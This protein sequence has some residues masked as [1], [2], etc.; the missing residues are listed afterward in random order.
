MQ[1]TFSQFLMLSFLALM[2]VAYDAK[3]SI[4]VV[5]NLTLYN[6]QKVSTDLSINSTVNIGQSFLATTPYITSISALFS[7]AGNCKYSIYVKKEGTDILNSSS[8][9]DIDKVTTGTFVSQA[10]SLTTITPASPIYVKVGTTYV[11]VFESNTIPVSSIGLYYKVNDPYPRGDLFQNYSYE[12]NADL[13]MTVVGGYPFQRKV[14]LYTLSNYFPETSSPGVY[15]LGN[16]NAKKSI[17]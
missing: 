14:D 11:I 16:R 3:A 10:G 13:C 5:D 2:G 7:T 17:V 8:N 15:L 12:K 1:K 4:T 9:N 6:Q